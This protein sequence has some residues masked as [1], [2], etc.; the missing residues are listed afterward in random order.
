MAGIKVTP[1]EL[2]KQGGDVIGYAGEI[3]H[4]LDSLDKKV[5]AVIDAWDGLAQ[6][7]FFQEYEKLKKELDKFP[8]VVEGLGK[9]IKGAAEAFE[10][11]DSE[12]A[13]LFNK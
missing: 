8:D 3:K 1:E 10:K 4:S 12:L 5:D 11:T 9:Q 7:G 6:D 13:K 2:S